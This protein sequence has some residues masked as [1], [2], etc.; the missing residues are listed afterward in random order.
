MTLQK[1]HDLRFEF[2]NKMFYPM[3]DE[4]HAADDGVYTSY[5]QDKQGRDYHAYYEDIHV[6]LDKWDQPVKVVRI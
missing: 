3:T 5:V 2:E 6:Q 4:V 1:R